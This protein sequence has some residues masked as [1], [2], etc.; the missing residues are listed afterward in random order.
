[1]I[2][3]VYDIKMFYIYKYFICMAGQAVPPRDRSPAGRRVT[4]AGGVDESVAVFF[5]NS[6]CII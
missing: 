6:V 5:K 1:M 2:Y 4:A 3:D